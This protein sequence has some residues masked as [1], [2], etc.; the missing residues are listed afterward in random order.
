MKPAHIVTG[1]IH[2]ANADKSARLLRV[3]GVLSEGR[4]VSTLELQERARV[5]APGTVCSELRAN[6]YVVKCVRRGRVWYYSL[7]GA[8]RAAA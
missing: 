6:G 3:L 1:D 2:A 8:A 5:C 7:P 4:E